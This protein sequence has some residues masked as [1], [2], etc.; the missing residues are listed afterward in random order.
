MWGLVHSAS[1]EVSSQPGLVGK[2][3]RNVDGRAGEVKSGRERAASDKAQRVFP[4]MALQ[5]KYALFG[6]IANFG[7]LDRVQGILAR[8]KG[9][10]PVEAGGVAR[11]NCG[12]LVPVLSIDFNRIR[13]GEIPVRPAKWNGINATIKSIITLPLP[14]GTRSAGRRPACRDEASHA[15]LPVPEAAGRRIGVAARS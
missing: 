7:S 9:L 3:S 4:N 2:A 14:A 8:P 6:N 11:V 12:A 5:V 1:N 13:H 15:G 10:E